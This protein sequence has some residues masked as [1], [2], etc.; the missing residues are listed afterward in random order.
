VPRSDPSAPSTETPSPSIPQPSIPNVI[1]HPIA[2]AREILAGAGFEPRVKYS[3]ERNSSGIVLDQTGPLR[4]SGNNVVDL[5]VS[6]IATVVILHD[7]TTEQ[8]AGELASYMYGLVGRGRGYLLRTESRGRPVGEGL[9]QYNASDLSPLVGQLARGAGEWL[10]QRYGRRI[11]LTP[12]LEPGLR[13]DIILLPVPGAA[14]AQVRRS[15]TPE[16][17]LILYSSPAELTVAE[18]LAANLSRSQGWRVQTQQSSV[19]VRSEGQIQYID[20]QLSG[21]AR[22]LA[23]DA[24]AWLSRAYR[25]SVVLTPVQGGRAGSGTLA[26]L[27]P[28]PASRGRVP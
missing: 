5:S 19:T 23:Q 13:S 26:L 16:V 10:T 22:I 12:K 8:T 3:E 6:A 7:S 24:G 27:L 11:E 25:R 14:P 17:V 9:I 2:N 20:D 21:A 1:G 4:G 15:E 28:S 18:Q